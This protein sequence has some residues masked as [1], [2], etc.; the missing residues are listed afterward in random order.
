[1][2]WTFVLLAWLIGWGSGLFVAYVITRRQLR[3]MSDEQAASDER[4]FVDQLQRDAAMF[5]EHRRR[6]DALRDDM[7]R[8]YRA[9][10]ARLGCQEMEN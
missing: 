4:F 5:A 2:S 7:E 3:R 8:R 1:M 9:L 10:R 6:L